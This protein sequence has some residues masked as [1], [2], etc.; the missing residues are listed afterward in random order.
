MQRGGSHI[1]WQEHF[2]VSFNDLQVPWCWH[3]LGIH[4]SLS[5]SEFLRILSNVIKYKAFEECSK[6]L[7]P[8][9]RYEATQETFT[10]SKSNTRNAK[11]DEK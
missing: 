8:K 1:P 6:Y 4:G 7:S 3:G 2:A 10:C 11:K 9:T 5:K